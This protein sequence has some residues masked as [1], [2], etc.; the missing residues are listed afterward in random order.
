MPP[1]SGIQCRPVILFQ[2]FDHNSFTQSGLVFASFEVVPQ[3]CVRVCVLE[4]GQRI[5][6]RRRPIEKLCLPSRWCSWMGDSFVT[7]QGSHGGLRTWPKRAQRDATEGGHTR[8]EVLL[9]KELPIL[10]RADLPHLLCV[11]YMNQI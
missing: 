10:P 8:Q 3:V 5:F 7:L 11:S 4:I 1:Y 2:M 6:E 9:S